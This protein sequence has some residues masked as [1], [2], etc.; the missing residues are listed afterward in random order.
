MNENIIN[1]IID[2]ISKESI[3]IAI[4]FSIVLWLFRTYQK[5]ILKNKE[6]IDATNDSLLELLIE[7]TKKIKA[8][9]VDFSF[10]YN[11][12][13]YTETEEDY[14][15]LKTAIENH[16]TESLDNTIDTMLSRIQAKRRDLLY[17]PENMINSLPCWFEKIGLIESIAYPFM[18]TIITLYTLL[19]ILIIMLSITS[20][21]NLFFILFFFVFWVFDSYI[22]ICKLINKQREFESSCLIVAYCL[23]FFSPIVLLINDVGLYIAVLLLLLSTVILIRNTSDLIDITSKVQRKPKNII[24]KLEGFYNIHKNDDTKILTAKDILTF[25]YFSGATIIAVFQFKKHENKQIILKNYVINK[26]FKNKILN[27]CDSIKNRIEKT[28]KTKIILSD[29]QQHLLH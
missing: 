16:D 18:C 8:L 7:S 26:S 19:S 27:N 23:S 20:P 21:I 24:D 2:L 28:T 3:S 9:S 5:N 15:K 11:L 1:N 14:Y 4:I 22:S 25:A 29:N 17:Y 6:K 13:Q 10:F 12:L